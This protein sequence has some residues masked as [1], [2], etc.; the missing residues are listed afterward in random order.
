MDAIIGML[1][2]VV[3]GACVIAF[4]AATTWLVVRISPSK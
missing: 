1:G 2:L 4:A 3:F